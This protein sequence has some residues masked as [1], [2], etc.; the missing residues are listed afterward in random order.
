M[1]TMTT[2][3]L[4]D[5][6]GIRVGHVTDLDGATGCTVIL[7]PEGTIG[8]GEVRGGAPGTRE[9]ALLRSE[10]AVETVNAVVLSG[11]SAFGLA[12]A[13]G[14]MRWLEEHDIGYDTRAGFKVPI[15]P[16][17]IL[18]DLALGTRGV[19]PTAESGY[20]ACQNASDAPVARGNVGAGTGARIGAMLGNERAT[21]GGLGSVSL[22]MGG[23][24][25]VAA[26]MAVNSVGDVVEADGSLLAGVRDESGAFL[27]ALKL[28]RRDEPP[29]SGAE[30]TVIGV[31][32]TNARLT[33]AQ[34][35]RV[36][37]MAHDGIARAVHPA[38]T[39]YDGDSLFVL[40]TGE[41]DAPPTSIG[42]FAA[43]AVAEAIRDGVRAATSLGP[44][45]AWNA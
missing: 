41:L 31:V 8:G 34:A 39:L 19:R 25:R 23:G 3:T 24:L 42:A 28:M 1:K 27:G 16:A 40:A 18:F 36:A 35:N 30:N 4:T 33:R 45:R 22:D 11:G 37:M 10:N 7:C 26:L 44:V 29:A 17:A 5:I 14:V 32:A 20:Q 15:V 2:M 43:Q 6:P 21:K 9:T 12:A 13:D 38:H